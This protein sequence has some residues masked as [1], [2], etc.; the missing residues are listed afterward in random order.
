MENLAGSWSRALMCGLFTW[1]HV[2]LSG[3]D[4]HSAGS[5]FLPNLS[6]LGPVRIEYLCIFSKLSSIPLQRSHP[7][8]G[9]MPK[10]SPRMVTLSNLGRQT[11]FPKETHSTGMVPA[12]HA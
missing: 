2:W 5:C 8:P 1:S 11:V 4:S 12:S 6:L 7:K 10:A 9:E 3:S